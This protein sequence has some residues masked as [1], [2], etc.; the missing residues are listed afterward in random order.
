MSSNG[1]SVRV[2]GEKREQLD[3][4]RFARAMLALHAQLLQEA[5]AVAEGQVGETSTEQDDRHESARHRS[6]RSTFRAREVP[7][8]PD[9]ATAR[10]TADHGGVLDDDELFW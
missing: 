7:G 1:R 10:K 2:R 8:T 6:R 5:K 4:A 3:I 9:A